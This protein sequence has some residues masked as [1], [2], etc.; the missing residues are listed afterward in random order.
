[1]SVDVPYVRNFVKELSP[2]L[3]RAA[4]ALNG[5]A[6]PPEDSF[7]YC[8][9]G[10]GM[11]D[12]LVTL[13][14][15]YPRARFVGV[16]LDPRHVA[17]GRAL[18]ARGRV[19]NVRF[20][21]L[22]FDDLDREPWPDLDYVAAHGVLSWI[23]PSKVRRILDFAAARLRP[24]GALTVSY[25]A[26]PGWAALEPLRRLM[27]DVSASA[28]G[29]SVDRARHGM[30]IARLFAD[31]GA[32]YFR[33]HPTA[34]EMLDTVHDSGATYAAHEYLG[35]HWHPMYFADVAAEM[36]R[37]ELLFAGQLPL[38]LNF[39]DLVIPTHTRDLFGAMT[40]RLEFESL[41]DFAIN[42]LFRR[43]L[44]VK[45]GSRGETT[46]RE[47]LDGTRFG[48][49]VPA[50]RVKR[51]VHLRHHTLRFEGDF[52]ALIERLSRCAATLP[53]LLAEPPFDQL[54]AQVTRDAVLRLLVGEQVAP[55]RPG[56]HP[57][58]DRYNQSVLED[59]PPSTVR[60]VLA[61][62]VA[63]TGVTLSALDA[64]ALRALMHAA[65]EREAWLRRILTERPL[66]MT[67]GER[68]VTDVDEQ[69]RIIAAHIALFAGTSAA[70]LV[71][72][73]VIAHAGRAGDAS[74][75]CDACDA[76]DAM[77]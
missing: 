50:D 9:L 30:A 74:D 67:Q 53:E 63:G 12:T 4:A 40:S 71:E 54:G 8:E 14:A 3:L 26:L 7:D 60:L 10:C 22:D 1:M 28:Q 38:Y 25:N 77:E 20:L 55:M 64:V 69:L 73:G 39:R 43:D 70:K 19:A 29:T 65:P 51:E 66:R 76:C 23:A 34:R 58:A 17:S 21:E 37:R 45:H 18:A 6:P 52:D 13:A 57:S 56:A 35:E 27:R 46:A 16:D 33:S 24:G 41:K 48:T 62:P 49:L 2:A 36:T 47:Y 75:A 44:Y 59:S 42:E 31:A 61:S 15:A 72:L 11:G 5:F 32:E 68:V